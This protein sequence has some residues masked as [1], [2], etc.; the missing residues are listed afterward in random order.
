SAA[1]GSRP[2]EVECSL[3]SRATGGYPGLSFGH[4]ITI[5]DFGTIILGKVTI[6][7]EDF[8]PD[9][10]IPRKTTVQLKMVEFHFGCVIAGG[11]GVGDGSTN[12]GT[13]P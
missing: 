4:V 6:K 5:P 11:A 7:H 3:V 13:A 1:L 2:E 12:G 9:S 8:K 10:G